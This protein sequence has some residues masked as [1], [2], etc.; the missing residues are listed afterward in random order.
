MGILPQK[1]YTAV[2]EIE[3]YI[4]KFRNKYKAIGFIEQF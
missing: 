3:P 2:Y 4:N 1:D